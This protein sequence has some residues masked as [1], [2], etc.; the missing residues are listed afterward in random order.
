MQAAPGTFIEELIK[1]DAL[2]A[3]LQRFFSRLPEDRLPLT[4]LQLMRFA[5]GWS[6]FA[7]LRL[8]TRALGDLDDIALNA[9]EL[10]T[11]G[12]GLDVYNAARRLPIRALMAHCGCGEIEQVAAMEDADVA[13]VGD[14]VR[15]CEIGG[16]VMGGGGTG[17]DD[18]VD[19]H[20]RTLAMEVLGAVPSASCF[21]RIGPTM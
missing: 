9:V 17:G 15:Y 16:D 10:D 6:S 12:G 5:F 13:C 19:G 1:E 4:I 11:A 14:L 18:D 21:L 8:N 20:V 2:R 3:A 7:T